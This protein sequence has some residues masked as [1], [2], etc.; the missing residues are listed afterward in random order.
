[1][2]NIYPFNS[3]TDLR[4]LAN[5]TQ[6]VVSQAMAPILERAR[7]LH[8]APQREALEQVRQVLNP[9]NSLGINRLPVYDFKQVTTG[10]SE[11]MRDKMYGQGGG[12]GKAALNPMM[13]GVKDVGASLV[14]QAT[15]GIDFTAVA[16]SASD[17]GQ[18]LLAQVSAGARMNALAEEISKTMSGQQD[19]YTSVFQKL[20]RT[21]D[22]YQPSSLETAISLVRA[23]PEFVEA[24]RE[25]V[26]EHPEEVQELTSNVSWDDFREL[27]PG[28]LG[29]NMKI[30]APWLNAFATISGN[31]FAG[32]TGTALAYIVFL[33]ILVTLI[34]TRGELLENQ[35]NSRKQIDP[36]EEQ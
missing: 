6:K 7:N 36:P 33:T 34:S 20:E 2:K 4:K 8:S 16:K 17:R 23:N 26:E 30:A 1:M 5:P 13:L 29:S 12:V 28:T 21:L 18:D 19:I 32:V 14:S 10:L 9:I 25:L 22:F 11:E 3:Q 27:F 15:R 31:A 24:T 35:K